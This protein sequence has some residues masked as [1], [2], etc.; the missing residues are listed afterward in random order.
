[1][2]SDGLRIFPTHQ[3]ANKELFSGKRS[4]EAALAGAEVWQ[5]GTQV[6]PCGYTMLARSP[7]IICTIGLFVHFSKINAVLN[8][9]SLPLAEINLIVKPVVLFRIPSCFRV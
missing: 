9:I 3:K 4:T 1:M 5:S 7:Y 2:R 6:N 8:S